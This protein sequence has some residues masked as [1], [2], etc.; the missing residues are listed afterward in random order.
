MKTKI[1][2]ALFVIVGVVYLAK[3]SLQTNTVDTGY[4]GNTIS[5]DYEAAL[6]QAKQQKKKVFIVFGADWCHWCHKLEEDTLSKQSVQTKL[7]NYVVL[8]VNTDNNRDLARKYGARGLPSYVVTDA[9][10]VSLKKG[11][12]YKTVSEFLE[13][14]EG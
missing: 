11:S 14:L 9:D 5:S 4:Y 8:H 7:R 2:I 12:G 3:V 6:A 1:I 10:G 13:W